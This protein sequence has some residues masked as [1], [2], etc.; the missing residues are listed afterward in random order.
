METP[1]YL[2]IETTP[3]MGLRIGLPRS[4]WHPGAFSSEVG[5]I[6]SWWQG[7]S[8]VFD[9]SHAKFSMPQLTHNAAMLRSCIALKLE[10]L[11][12]P[13]PMRFQW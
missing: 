10:R 3:Q 9:C 13:L 7:Y 5:L 2:G 6:N 8:K 12:T 4:S 11:R 1:S